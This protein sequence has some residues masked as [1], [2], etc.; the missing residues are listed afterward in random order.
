MEWVPRKIHILT[1]RFN[2]ASIS[3]CSIRMRKRKSGGGPFLVL[4]G[5]QSW[6]GL[7]I[8]TSVSMPR[9]IV[10][11][12]RQ[13]GEQ[14]QATTRTFICNPICK[15]P[16]VLCCLGFSRL[17]NKAGVYINIESE[18]RLENLIAKN[19]AP[20]SANWNGGELA[21]WSSFIQMHS[22]RYLYWIFN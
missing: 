3:H 4:E 6:E 5:M 16:C 2:S 18:G 20:I 17:E 11:S 13:M 9:H 14:V 8:L 15:N 19:Y 12:S 22:S 1:R 21:V 7:L 10:V